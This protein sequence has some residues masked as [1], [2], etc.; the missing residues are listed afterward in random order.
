MV[1]GATTY[2]LITDQVGS[3]RLVLDA[4]SGAVAERIDWDEFGNVLSD[5]AP[6]T[7]PFGFAGGLR[8]LD[9]GLIRFGARD[10]D[11]S[12]GRWTSKD[13]LRF[14]GGLLDFYDYVGD[15]PINGT[16]GDGLFPGRGPN[17]NWSLRRDPYEW[18][19]Q[20]RKLM[21]RK[22]DPGHESQLSDRCRELEKYLE[23]AC[24]VDKHLYAELMS[25][26]NQC[27]DRFPGRFP[28]AVSPTEGDD[29]SVARVVVGAGGAY[30]IYRGVRLVP[31]LFP[32]LWPT[33]PVNAALP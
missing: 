30:L 26:M 2:R 15:D 18:I 8:D 27:R 5:T 23:G 33:I 3:V 6:G 11:P 13:P 31:S 4:S 7:Q 19:E 9:S 14:E 1:Q 25:Q 10:Y 17:H 29:D 28:A 12:T 22:N 32:P 24:P 20:F 16:D 21:A